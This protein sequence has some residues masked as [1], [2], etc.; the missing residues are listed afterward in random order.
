MA[1]RKYLQSLNFKFP[2]YFLVVYRIMVH[3]WLIVALPIVC[4]IRTWPPDDFCRLLHALLIMQSRLLKVRDIL[5]VAKNTTF[6]ITCSHIE[7]I[8]RLDF[9][10]FELFLDREEELHL[11]FAQVKFGSEPESVGMSKK[12]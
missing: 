12:N 5:R 8:R 2:Y 9:L 4:E 3:C 7:Y 6:Y 11:N 1:F 10:I